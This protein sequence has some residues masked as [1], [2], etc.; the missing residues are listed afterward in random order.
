M[1]LT[2]LLDKKN[3]VNGNSVFIASDV[4]DIVESGEI[5]KSCSIITK[6]ESNITENVS[7]F[8]PAFKTMFFITFI[9]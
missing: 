9:F 8:L 4:E 1:K 7:Y 5:S 3:L 2:I 6:N